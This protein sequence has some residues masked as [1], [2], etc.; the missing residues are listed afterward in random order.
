M[1]FAARLIL[2]VVSAV[3]S[4]CFGG[5][6]GA[7]AL[8]IFCEFFDWMTGAD[9]GDKLVAKVWPLFFLVASCGAILLATV[10]AKLAWNSPWPGETPDTPDSVDGQWKHYKWSND[11]K[12]GSE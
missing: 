9:S 3:V 8:L 1:K 10:V 5:A 4:G 11:S 7:F 12:T 6:I 2:T